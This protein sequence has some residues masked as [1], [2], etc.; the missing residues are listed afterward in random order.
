MES[1]FMQLN[2]FVLYA[3][4]GAL[5]MGLTGCVQQ[6]KSRQLRSLSVGMSKDDVVD[7]LGEPSIVRGAMQTKSGPLEVFE[8]S[9]IRETNVGGKIAM[10]ALLTICTLGLW[11]PIAIILESTGSADGF[12]NYWLYF[13]DNRLV[14]WGKPNDWEQQATHVQEFRFR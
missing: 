12:E 14:K 5:F 6:V 10:H 8:Y 13:S 7:N 11:L 2:K 3:C 4:T 9:V 1:F